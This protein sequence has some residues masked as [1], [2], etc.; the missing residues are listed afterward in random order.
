[1]VK[2]KRN[3]FSTS[4]RTNVSILTSDGDLQHSTLTLNQLRMDRLATE[5]ERGRLILEQTNAIHQ[6]LVESALQT[7]AVP[8]TVIADFEGFLPPEAIG[9]HEEEPEGDELADSDDDRYADGEAEHAARQAIVRCLTGQKSHRRRKDY[10]T[11]LYKNRRM[12]SAW[13]MDMPLLVQGYLEWKYGTQHNESGETNETAHMFDVAVVSTFTYIPRHVVV[14][15]AGECANTALLRAGLLGCSPV[16]PTVAI[17]LQCLELFHQIRRRQSSFSTQTMARVLCALHN[18]ANDPILVPDRMHAMDGNSSVKR[19]TGS[20]HADERVLASHL[21]ISPEDVDIFKDDVKNKPG[22]EPAT[23]QKRPGK[24]SDRVES[25]RI[26]A[27]T[28]C[29]DRWGATVAGGAS[30]ETVQMFEQTGIFLCACRHGIVE[31]VAE[32]RHSGEL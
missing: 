30:D 11:R 4:T 3:G 2:R 7:G 24:K 21:F 10:R 29:A 31:S 17:D 5:K 9:E 6:A 12:W 26:D 14:Q 22:K 28:A 32:M 19:M 16:Q 18:L 13:E 20:G 25:D 8:S 23:R 15:H 27:P 1:M